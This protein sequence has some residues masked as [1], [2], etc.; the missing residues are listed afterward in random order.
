M[1]TT[2]GL[3]HIKT[4]MPAACDPSALSASSPPP[5]TTHHGGQAGADTGA[6]LPTGAKLTSACCRVGEDVVLVA[7]G[8]FARQEIGPYA[9]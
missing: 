6:W 3:R 5:E 8:H 1:R 7:S 9:N 2:C 4:E